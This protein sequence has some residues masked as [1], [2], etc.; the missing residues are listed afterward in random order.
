MCSTSYCICKYVAVCCQYIS[1]TLLTCIS[2]EKFSVYMRK[3]GD[4]YLK[5]SG[6]RTFNISNH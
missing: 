2:S 1:Q 4:S 5:T 6:R 3:G